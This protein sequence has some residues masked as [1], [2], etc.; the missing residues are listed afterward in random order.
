MFHFYTYFLRF[1]NICVIDL[2]V[3]KFALVSFYTYFP[4][5]LTNLQIS[6]ISQTPP[7]TLQGLFWTTPG[8]PPEPGWTP[9]LEKTWICF[10]FKM[11]FFN[12]LF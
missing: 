6:I 8:H 12:V 9:F 2:M 4:G 5:V 1:L 7:Q 3:Y 11:I 10:S